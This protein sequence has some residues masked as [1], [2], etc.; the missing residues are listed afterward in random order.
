MDR[1]RVQDGR[2]DPG[3]MNPRRDSLR[4]QGTPQRHA[5]NRTIRK[6]AARRLPTACVFASGTRRRY[7]QADR[8]RSRDKDASPGQTFWTRAS[9]GLASAAA[10][11]SNWARKP[12]RHSHDQHS[13]RE[14]S[15][16]SR[17]KQSLNLLFV[18]LP[19]LPPAIGH[20][21]SVSGQF[22]AP[23]GTPTRLCPCREGKT[24]PAFPMRQPSPKAHRKRRRIAALSNLSPTSIGIHSIPDLPAPC[25]L[26]IPDDKSIEQATRRIPGRP[27]A[28][29]LTSRPILGENVTGSTGSAVVRS[30]AGPIGWDTAC[31]LH[32][33]RRSP[34]TRFPTPSSA[35]I[36]QSA[37]T[38]S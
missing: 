25:Q 17:V 21:Q 27:P 5:A 19:W 14:T 9:I 18:N 36:P 13:G 4:G 20:P 26:A 1:A 23:S 10:S 2:K 15:L 35:A 29:H 22:I 33:P 16:R 3:T 24:P 30:V 38:S 7:P 37:D 11:S 31:R 8:A 6:R 28:R 12:C 32:S 34:R